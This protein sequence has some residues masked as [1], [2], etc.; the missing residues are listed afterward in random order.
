MISNRQNEF[1]IQR[2]TC[3]KNINEKVRDHNRGPGTAARSPNSRNKLT[4]KFT[5]LHVFF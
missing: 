5:P 4:F 1:S 2:G 3:Y